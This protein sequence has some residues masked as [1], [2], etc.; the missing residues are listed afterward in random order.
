MN[1]PLLSL[2]QSILHYLCQCHV[3]G[4]LQSLK[5]L[6]IEDHIIGLLGNMTVGEVMH[7]SSIKVMLANISIDNSMLTKLLNRARSQTDSQKL[8]IQLIENSAPLVLVNELTGIT[9]IEFASLRK[10]L[11]IHQLGRTPS[12]S[13][14]ETDCIYKAWQDYDLRTDLT[15]YEWLELANSTKLPIKTIYK[16]IIEE[17]PEEVPYA[18]RH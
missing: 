3:D 12:P 16:V 4:D 1:D 11:N 2:N 18:K 13:N 6:G 7:M 15:A 10:Q 17:K 14:E 9:G 5:K 8:L